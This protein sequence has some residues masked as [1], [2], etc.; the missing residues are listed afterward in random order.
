[1]KGLPIKEI[2]GDLGNVHEKPKHGDVLPHHE[3][4]LGIVG[5][6]S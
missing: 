2:P 5:N 6:A 1:M 4:V 3:F